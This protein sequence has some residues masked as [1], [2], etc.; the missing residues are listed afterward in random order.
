MTPI[1]QKEYNEHLKLYA[2][3]MKVSYNWLSCFTELSPLEKLLDDLITI[4][5]EVSS[6]ERKDN[7][8][9]IDLEVLVSRHD[10]LSIIGLA[11]DIAAFSGK[12]LRY[13]EVP[14][15]GESL[16]ITPE[17]TIENPE[18]CP[19]YTGRV[20]SNIKILESPPLIKE[21]LLH[22][23]I[24]P[25][26]NIVDITN[27]V[28]LEMGHPMHSFDYDK[29]KGPIFIRS[30]KEQERLLCLDGNVYDLKDSIVIADSERP[31]AIGGIIGGKE[32]SVSASTKTI[33]LEVAYFSPS[34]IRKAA[35]R[36]GITTESS[37]RFE[38]MIDP[39]GLINAQNR[40]AALI[41]EQIKDAKIGPIVDVYPKPFLPLKI[42][43]RKDRV[44]KI[45]GTSLNEENIKDILKRLE[46]EV[47]D[48]LQVKIPSFRGEI[49]REID[50]IEEI[51]RIYNYERIGKKMP[52]SLITGYTNKTFSLIRRVR[53]IMLMCGMD[54]VITYS[55]TNKETLQKL[56][57]PL[58]HIIPL[59]SP[60]S[61]DCEV[62]TPSLIIGLL[63]IARVNTSHQE[64]NLSI[65]QIGKVFEKGREH[66]SL[67]G[68]MTGRKVFNFLD[69]QRD[70]TLYDLLGVIKRLFLEFGI[71][72]NFI[73][74]DIPFLKGGLEI[75]FDD[76]TFGIT[77]VLN[78]DI[79]RYYKIKR[80]IFLFEL[81]VDILISHHKGKVFREFSKYP[82][83]T[84]DLCLVVPEDIKSKEIERI[85]KENGEGLVKE[86]F[87]YDIYKETKTYRVIYQSDER[88]LLM[89]EIKRIREKTLEE[90]KRINVGLR[91]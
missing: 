59:Q 82:K 53:E 6:V 2:V 71:D 78:E 15:I 27:Y 62:L 1:I 58:S 88:T 81:D 67:A 44:N 45:L 83:V 87:P 37:Y 47:D 20:I 21:R 11:R 17:I 70:F 50:L 39:E 91:R 4:G 38:R 26:N 5:F 9:I 8:F 54:E 85:I 34:A 66:T 28:L 46:F 7:D 84:L 35:K 42:T 30:G 60:L 12:P 25:V 80:P 61:S 18:L 79:Q 16:T 55:F 36:L 69:R 64:E 77:G 89:D 14:K 51:A 31:I 29:I 13:P 33:L 49:K 43:L 48:A 76:K 52:Q 74:K 24:R 23:G 73:K 72:C 56:G 32:T 40:A 68:L 10:A 19:R 65:F 90:L 41:L 22:C 63:E 57:F 86:V 3:S 75:S